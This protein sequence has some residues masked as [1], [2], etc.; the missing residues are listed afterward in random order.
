M[1]LRDV[2]RSARKHWVWVVL[3]VVALTAAMAFVSTRSAPVYRSTATL[4]I[5]LSAGSSAGDLNQ[6]SSYTQSQ[7]TSFA[8]LATLPVTLDPVVQELGLDTTSRALAGS[9]AATSPKDSS[10]LDV[11]VTGSSPEL[12]A[13]VANAVAVRLGQVVE[14]LAPAGEAGS[15]IRATVVSEAV[16]PGA[17]I[18]PSTRRNVLAG[19]IAG[20]LLG[21]VAAWARTALDTRVFG[22]I[23]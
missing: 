21:L 16:A 19:F 1:T 6:G 14:E 10:L 20:V 2:L 23:A 18:A 7:M 5:A 9:V 11:A 4:Y 8:R 15:P 13:E 3:P 12:T 17:P 22:K